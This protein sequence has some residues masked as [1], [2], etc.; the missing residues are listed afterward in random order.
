MTDRIE[1]ALK[2]LLAK[3][4]SAIKKILLLI[5]D[6]KTESLDIKKLKGRDDIYRV[7]KGSLRIFLRKYDGKWLLLAIERRSDTTY[8]KKRS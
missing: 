7:R 8:N 3:E 6:G 5:K 4:R 1:K 2:K